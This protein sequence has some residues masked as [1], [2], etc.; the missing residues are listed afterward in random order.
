MNRLGNRGGERYAIALETIKQSTEVIR[1]GE[2]E[3]QQFSLKF[4]SLFMQNK[5]NSITPYETYKD[6]MVI[7]RQY[8]K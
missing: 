3:L 7:S 4:L 2:L 5:K 8:I 6:Y 1:N